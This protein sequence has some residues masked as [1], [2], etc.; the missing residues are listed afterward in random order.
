MKSRDG[1][2]IKIKIRDEHGRVV[3][4]IDA[5][6]FKG[7][8]SLAHDDGLRS[9]RTELVQFPT[10]D[11]GKTAVVR[12]QIKT[13]TGSFTGIGDASPS[14]VNR[15]IAPHIIR[16]AET[17]AV[18]RAFRVAVNIGE[19]A[20]EELFDGVS[21]A[22]ENT[23]AAPRQNAPG[24]ARQAASGPELAKRTSES[25]NDGNGRPR[26]YRGRDKAPTEVDPSDRRGMS[27]EQRKLLFRL[28]Y[29]LGEGRDSAPDKVLDTLGKESFELATRVDA[30]RA[31]DQLKAELRQKRSN[32]GKEARD[33]AQSA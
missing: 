9:V 6:T 1:F 26:P 18:A 13:S 8:L 23:S 25:T 12:A 28:A 20:M 7:L 5:V 31:I 19:V 4:E 24:V 11:N 21:T 22:D 10:G 33:A 15:R 14:N 30:S 32:G 17:R 2:I 27:G 29:E 3:D 16:M